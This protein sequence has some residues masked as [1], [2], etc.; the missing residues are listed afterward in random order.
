MPNETTPFFI[1]GLKHYPE[2]VV[3][4]EEFRRQ[5]A[6]RIEDLVRE[7]S[8]EW[9]EWRVSPSSEFRSTRSR[10]YGTWVGAGGLLLGPGEKKATIEIGIW[11]SCAHQP[12]VPVL[13][14]AYFSTGDPYLRKD[15]AFK[16]ELGGLKVSRWSG[17]TYLWLE[18]RRLEDHLEDEL[19]RLLDGCGR[20]ICAAQ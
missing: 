12:N 1:A 4:E 16:S 18:P 14:A 5:L 2:A 13:L 8:K 15:L 9:G 11:W 17:E 6:L 10:V 3:A 19:R 7:R 20:V